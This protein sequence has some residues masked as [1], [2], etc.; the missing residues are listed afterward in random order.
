[1][2]APDCDAET[3]P[4]MGRGLCAAL[5]DSPDKRLT[6]AGCATRA[7]VIERKRDVLSAGRNLFLDRC[8]DPSDEEC[9][10]GRQSR[11]VW[12]RL[13][14]CSGYF[15]GQAYEARSSVKPMKG[16]TSG[17]SNKR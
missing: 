1:M 7:V 16:S 11:L 9:H 10:A 2:M 15:R 12:F 4:A 8:P 5:F 17:Q 6:E 3:P 13:N 14:G